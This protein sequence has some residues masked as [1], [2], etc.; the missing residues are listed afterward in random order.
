MRVKQ[1]IGLWSLA[2]IGSGILVLLSV[3]P[4]IASEQDD[5]LRCAMLPDQDE[6]HACIDRV[7]EHLESQGLAEMFETSQVSSKGGITAGG[8]AEAELG[9]E[10]VATKTVARAKESKARPVFLDLEKITYGPRRKARFHLKNGQIWRQV[11]LVR[12]SD[13]NSAEEVEIKKGAMG[14][15]QLRLSGQR[16]FMRVRRIK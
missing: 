9:A 10:Q 1:P 16:Q 12:F 5:A 15:Y 11:E 6:R 8:S 14:G 13:G 7:A 4:V 3:N 2:V